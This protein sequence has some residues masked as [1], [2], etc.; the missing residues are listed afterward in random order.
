MSP[1]VNNDHTI[2]VV[3]VIVLYINQGC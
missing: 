1:L 3:F 2:K